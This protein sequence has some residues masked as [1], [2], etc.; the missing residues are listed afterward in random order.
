[1]GYTV[2]CSGGRAGVRCEHQGMG[3]AVIGGIPCLC[4]DKGLNGRG[5]LMDLAGGSQPQGHTDGLPAS[6]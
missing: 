1:M 3:D 4:S 6:H 2:E 5:S